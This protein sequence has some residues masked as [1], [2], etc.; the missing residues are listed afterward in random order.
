MKFLDS[1]WLRIQFTWICLIYKPESDVLSDWLVKN[2]LSLTLIGCRG[3]S[4][5]IN[6]A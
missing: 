2:K 3:D 5:T 1:F 4:I 6:K